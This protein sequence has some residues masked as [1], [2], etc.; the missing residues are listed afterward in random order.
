M[1]TIM[2]K[3]VEVDYEK[4]AAR[5]APGPIARGLIKL[6][7]GSVTNKAAY[8]LVLRSRDRFQL[9]MNQ[10]LEKSLQG[11]KVRAFR[12]LDTEKEVYEMLKLEIELKQV[13]YN[14]VI[15]Q[16]LPKLLTG[17]SSQPGKTGQLG[18]L[19]LS[20]GEKPD[21]MLT[22]AL[23]LLSQEEKDELLEQIFDIYREDII[24]GLN[25]A[26]VQQNIAAVIA[27]VKLSKDS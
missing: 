7:P 11:V 6:L 17:M 25:R 10:A 21:R 9:F 12:F 4:L 24:E 16:L 23:N 2:I 22:A 13:D 26:A 8:H 18:K 5:F 15:T 1:F 14:S 19:L 27:E 20:L 3:L